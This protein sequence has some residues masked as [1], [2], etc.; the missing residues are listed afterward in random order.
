MADP[1]RVVGPTEFRRGLYAGT[2]ALR[3]RPVN[4]AH[5]MGG[6]HGFGPV[7][8]EATVSPFHAPWE[9][10]VCAMMMALRHRGVFN[11]DEMRRAIE[12]IPPS[13]YLAL[14]Y[15]ERWAMALHMLLLE[16]GQLTG[17]EIEATLHRFK[18]DPD[19]VRGLER[20]NSPSLADAVLAA[21]NRPPRRPRDTANPRFRPGDRVVAKN[22]HVKDHTRLPRYVRGRQGVIH[23]VHGDYDFP[24]TK[25]HGRGAHPCPVYS[26]RFAARELWGDAA[27]PRD[28]LYI[29]LWE[30]YLDPV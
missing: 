14:T 9:G 28:S 12:T 6:M 1:A 13:Q 16:K 27:S 25:A 29:D 30:N 18:Q 7:R 4:G 3:G 2:S 20:R 15:F 17:P 11:L 5:D 23:R 24:D 10:R 22:Q 21:M 8:P 26:V 19:L